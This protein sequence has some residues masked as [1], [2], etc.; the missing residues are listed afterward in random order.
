MRRAVASIPTNIAEGCGRETNAELSRFLQIAMGSVSEVEYQLILARD[1]D[2]LTLDTYTQLSE[3]LLRVK[4]ML[5]SLIQKV[6][7]AR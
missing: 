3:E 1:L 7:L 5:N 6:N 2:F 4:R